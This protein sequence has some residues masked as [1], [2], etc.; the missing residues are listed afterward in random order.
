MTQLK[1]QVGDVIKCKPGNGTRS[2]LLGV[3][4]SAG[5]RDTV[6]KVRWDKDLV[7]IRPYQQ[8]WLEAQCDIVSPVAE[9]AE[10]AERRGRYI[11]VFPDGS[12]KLIQDV[13]VES[14]AREF[15]ARWAKQAD[16]PVRLCKIVGTCEPKVKVTTTME[17]DDE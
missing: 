8:G 11:L 12:A 6:Y 3:V 9:P 15:A 2:N 1:F 14:E 5:G 7:D 4:V 13:Q 10:K 17:W 16:G